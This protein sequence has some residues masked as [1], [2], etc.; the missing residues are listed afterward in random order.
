MATS[1]WQNTYLPVLVLFSFGIHVHVFIF[2]QMIN[3][4]YL[5]VPLVELFQ[6]STTIG[7]FKTSLIARRT[8]KEMGGEKNGGVRSAKTACLNMGRRLN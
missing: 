8:L 3:L 7:H 5:K 2:T 1:I 4:F 6:N